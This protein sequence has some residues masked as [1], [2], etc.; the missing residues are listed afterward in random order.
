MEWFS[1]ESISLSGGAHDS[2]VV[3]LCG[4][5]VRLWKPTGAVSD[6]TLEELDPQGN[7][8]CDGQRAQGADS[9]ECRSC[10]EGEGSLAVLQEAQ[11]QSYLL[12]VGYEQ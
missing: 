4:S 6:T 9:C 11:H 5:K 2:E 8:P 7:F 12:Q 10:H 1:V 3:E